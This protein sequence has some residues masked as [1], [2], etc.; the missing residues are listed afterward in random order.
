M[1]VESAEQVE[2]GYLG[3]LRELLWQLADDDLVVAFRAS[4]WLGL[5][6]HV[7]EDVAFSSIAQDEM[8]H[9][10]MY[11]ELLEAL[12]EGNR[13]DISQLRPAVERRNAVLL[14]VPNGSGSY[15]QAPHFDWSFTIVRHYFY[16]VFESLRLERLSESSYLPL[17]QVAQKA[18]REEAY[19][20]AHQEIWMR[21]IASHS[22]DTRIR[23]AAALQT[24]AAVAGDLTFVHPWQELWQDYEIFPRAQSIGEAWRCQ[25][26]GLL[27]ELGLA[28]P[29]IGQ[30]SN[31]RL[32]EHSPHL[33]VLLDT[34]SEVYRIDS[35][36]KW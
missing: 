21:R 27:D 32:G 11:F 19:H 31:G 24:A 20:L 2:P 25:V 18:L 3:P 35:S 5:A 34:L 13:D 12:G 9:A 6:P 33:V 15:L 28:L 10:S 26:S 14:E 30:Q 7:E 23:L 1:V 22:A 29:E 16:D 17:A 36:A 4:E 8:G